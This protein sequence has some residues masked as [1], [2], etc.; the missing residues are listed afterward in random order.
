MEE[1]NIRRSEKG[2][3]FPWFGLGFLILVAAVVGSFFTDIPAKVARNLKEI[4]APKP[5]PGTATEP[6]GSSGCS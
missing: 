3:G 1:K 4:I 6:R 5:Q 2:K